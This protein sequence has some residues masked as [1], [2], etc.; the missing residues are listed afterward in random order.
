[1]PTYTYRCEK[2]KRKFEIQQSIKDAALKCCPN[3]GSKVER[4]ILPVGVVFKGGG[5]YKTDNRS[6]SKSSDGLGL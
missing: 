6:K 3:C 4:V 2:E 1:M 5:F